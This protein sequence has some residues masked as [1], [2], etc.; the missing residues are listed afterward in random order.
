MG[1]SGE[2]TQ[3]VTQQLKLGGQPLSLQLCPRYWLD[4]P[5]AAASGW[6]FRTAATLPLPK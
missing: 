5:D 2:S 4:S 6:A 3:T 1:P